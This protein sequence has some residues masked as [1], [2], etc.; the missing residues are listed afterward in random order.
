MVAAS[1]L[2][3][4][5]LAA[6]EAGGDPGIIAAGAVR[7]S[8]GACHTHMVALWMV[9]QAPSTALRAP[10]GAAFWTRAPRPR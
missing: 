2:A 4:E 7:I 10:A 9:L 5:R 6:A 1:L 8:F 3:G